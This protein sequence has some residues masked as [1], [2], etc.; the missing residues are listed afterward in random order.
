MLRNSLDLD[1]DFWLD[2]DPDS[3][4]RTTGLH[5]TAYRIVNF[6]LHLSNIKV[7]Q[8]WSRLFFRI[9]PKRAAPVPQKLPCAKIISIMDPDPYIN[10]PDSEPNY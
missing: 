4:I 7:G 8:S 1:S 10:L 9:Q 6:N 2:T 5:N 3:M